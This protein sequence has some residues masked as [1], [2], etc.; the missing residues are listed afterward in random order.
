M[1]SKL[2]LCSVLLFTFAAD[3][4]A[5]SPDPSA[6]QLTVA[7]VS[8]RARKWITVKAQTNCKAVKFIAVSPELDV[9]PSD[10][11]VSKT[12]TVL[13]ADSAG[14]FL[15]VAVAAKGDEI[16]EPVYVRVYVDTP[17]PDVPVP[18]GPGPPTPPVPPTPPAPTVPEDRFDNV[19]RSVHTL[20]STFPTQ[21]KALAANTAQLFEFTADKLANGEIASLNAAA[22]FLQ[23][24]RTKL[25]GAQS[26][27][28]SAFVAKIQEPWN[29]RWPLTKPD[30]IEFYRAVAAGLKAVK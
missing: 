25:W 20:V 21:S 16:S 14:V 10:Q 6:P 3:V 18:P 5:Q 15:L 4:V 8:G 12:S 7:D 23:T 13:T 28:W 1:V 22:G 27:D 29:K 2:L 30:V 26:S 19:G 11:L 17:M 9:F 24:E